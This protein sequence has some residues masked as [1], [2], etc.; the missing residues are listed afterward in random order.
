MLKSYRSV[1]LLA[2]GLAFAAGPA[3]ALQVVVTDISKNAN[4]TSTYHFSVKTDPGETLSAGKDFVTVYNFAGL[5]SGSAKSPATFAFSSR[6]YG[7][8]PS[9]DGYAAVLPIDMAGASNLTWTAKKA[10]PG[11][12]E[13]DGFSATTRVG[14]TT[15]GEYT[16]QVTVQSSK[17]KAAKQALIGQLPT[18]SYIA[19]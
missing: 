12:T 18:P 11:G 17:G 10:V 2:C 5:V 8:T 9:W 19:Q 15:Q 13:V 14:S 6:M 3:Q 1:L 4:G 7:E 16:A